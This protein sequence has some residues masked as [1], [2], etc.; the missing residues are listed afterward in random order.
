MRTRNQINAVLPDLVEP[1]R[2][3]E[4]ESEKGGTHQGRHDALCRVLERVRRALAA[5][6]EAV[7]PAVDGDEVEAVA[8][9]RVADLGA[10]ARQ[11]RA[12]CEREGECSS[13]RGSLEREMESR[14]RDSPAWMK[15]RTG[16]PG[17]SA[18]D[19]GK[20][21]CVARANEPG[22]GLRT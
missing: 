10:P 21:S 20:L 12:R 19:G 7:E 9:A 14:E 22:S 6:G 15:T 5:L 8:E 16:K 11:V 3:S 1:A 17:L 4:S 13:Q 18:F 2:E